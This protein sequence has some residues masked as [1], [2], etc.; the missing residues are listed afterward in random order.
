MLVRVSI[1][2]VCVAAASV[3]VREV[4]VCKCAEIHD[5]LSEKTALSSA[6]RIAGLCSGTSV[7]HCSLN[8]VSI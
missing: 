3:C 2:L 5:Q 4:L 1:V 8:G 6:L 7:G